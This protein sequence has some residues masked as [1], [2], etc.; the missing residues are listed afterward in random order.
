MRSKSWCWFLFGTLLGLGFVCPV[1]GDKEDRLKGEKSPDK[2]T[3][4]SS[5]ELIISEEEIRKRDK[6][7]SE[8]TQK[9][10]SASFRSGSRL[11]TSASASASDSSLK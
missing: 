8:E 4:A 1:S 10:K 9:H 6:S 7:E 11:K 2:R 5:E 3:K